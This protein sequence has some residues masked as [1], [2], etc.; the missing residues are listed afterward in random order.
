MNRATISLVL[1]LSA[2]HTPER[3][4][5][6]I[7]AAE[8]FTEGS[9]AIGLRAS[10]ASSDCDVLVI[11]ADFPLNT[12]DVEAIHYG[13]SHDIYG[14]GYMFADGVEPFYFRHRFRAV[15]YVGDEGKFW[16][17][18]ATYRDEVKRLKRCGTWWPRRVL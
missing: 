7:A 17:Y 15:V 14:A 13:P 6:Y 18:G 9:K 8:R 16:T 1:L 5:K 2:C 12:R 10:A 3:H 11:E 4:Q